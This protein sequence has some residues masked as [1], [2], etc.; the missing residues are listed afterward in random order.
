MTVQPDQRSADHTID[1][2]ILTVGYNSA[3]YL[4]R[5]L[6]SLEPALGQTNIEMVFINNSEDRSEELIAQ[7]FPAVRT[8]PSQG[9][10][11]FGRAN[12]ILAQHAIGAW[13]LLL[14]PDTEVQPNAINNL[15]RAAQGSPDYAILSA[16][17]WIN[18][19]GSQ[20]LPRMEL[21]GIR[22]LARGLVGQSAKP[23]LIDP[24]LPITAAECVSG[25]CMMIRRDIWDE[26]G[27]FDEDFFLYAED[28]DLC[29]RAV[30][31]EFKLGIVRDAA[32]YHDLGSGEYFSPRRILLQMRGNAHYFRKH[33]GPL[34]ALGCLV[35]LWL[36]AIVRFA[37]GGVLGWRQ[38]KYRRMSQAFQSIALAPWKWWRGYRKTPRT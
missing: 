24:T 10:I 22:T 25:G 33:F 11:G 23:L 20:Q 6:A 28:I 17:T 21:P 14:N 19:D 13:L 30:G 37:I 34:H 9:N 2:S 36:S 27:G 18:R 15:L 38:I 4:E 32:I 5:S 1:L 12:N 35:T 7:K 31:K 26:L 3:Q 16:V 8:L 29:K